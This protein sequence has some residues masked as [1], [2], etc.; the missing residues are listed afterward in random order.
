MTLIQDYQTRVEEVEIYFAFV[1]QVDQIETHKKQNHQL[2]DGNQITIKRDLQKVIRANCYLLLYNLIESS[3]RNGLWHIY[4]AI[5]D[6]AVTFNEVSEKIKTIWLAQKTSE[7]NDINSHKKFSEK[8]NELITQQMMSNPIE[9]SKNRISLSGN[10]DYRSIDQIINDYGF[11]GRISVP[12]MSKLKKALLKV[13]SERNA[14]AHGNKSFR[15]AA[16]IIT[17]Q[18]LVEYKDLIVIYL[19]DIT[20]NIIE[21]IDNKRY[22][23]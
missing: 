15:Q 11:H 10:L 22:K 8:I 12:N 13:K 23:K 14:L 7:L 5:L 18:D 3:V 4:D 21:F 20:N 16:E 2:S 19:Q 1:L 9:M 6:E 17:I